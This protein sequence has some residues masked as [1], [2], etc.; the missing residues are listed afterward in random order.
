M[1]VINMVDQLRLRHI[2]VKGNSDG[3]NLPWTKESE[4]CDI[5]IYW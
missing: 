5:K 4:N 3:L 2:I 1:L